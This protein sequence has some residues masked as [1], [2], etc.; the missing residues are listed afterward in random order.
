MSDKV[1]E[2]GEVIWFNA[3]T[4]YGFISRAGN[5]DIFVHFSDI[6]SEGFKTLKKGQRVSYEIGTNKRGQP[7]AV[8]VV[9]VNVN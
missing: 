4:G 6:V 5:P 7:K 8:N 2:T 1:T 9:V 3:K